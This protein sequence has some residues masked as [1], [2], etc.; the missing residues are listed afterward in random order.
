MTDK[1]L[2]ALLDYQQM[3]EEGIMVL[4]SRE[5]IH[6]VSDTITA[7]RK[8]VEELRAEHDDAQNAL[9]E[10][11]A[12]AH[13]RSTGPAIPD[14]MWAIR[15]M[16]YRPLET[17]RQNRQRVKEEVQAEAE[18]GRLRSELP[19]MCAALERKEG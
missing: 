16:A 18:Y 3:D 15:D 17:D 13:E 14:E 6:E 8:E 4:T 1:A 10:I 5:A 12:Y 11:G 9:S 19:E 2:K 7:L